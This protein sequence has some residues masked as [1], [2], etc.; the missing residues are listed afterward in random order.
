MNKEIIEHSVD[1]LCNALRLFSECSFSV[2]QL[3]HID[4]EEAVD[5]HDRAFE[6]I[7]ESFHTLYDTSK[8]EVNYFNNPSSS[9][10][11]II[12]N[13]IH[14]RNHSLFNSWNRTMIRRDGYKKY[15]GAEF[16][17]CSYD[18]LNENSHVMQY[19]YKLDDIFT[20]LDNGQYIKPNNKKM[21]IDELNLNLI[22]NYASSQRY[23]LEQIYLNIIPVMCSAVRYA[24]NELI[25]KGIEPSGFD[26]EVY[27]KHFTTDGFFDLNSINYKKIRFGSFT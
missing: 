9:L 24:F 6:V 11:I 10:L 7:L 21:I 20:Q 25:K 18:P 26:S 2:K 12:R 13:A 22:K 5:N 8:K 23:P 27:L 16:L 4:K 1:R 19:Y 15:D 14:H 3:L 17:L